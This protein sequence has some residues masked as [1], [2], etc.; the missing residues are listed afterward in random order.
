MALRRVAARCFYHQRDTPII[1]QMPVEPLTDFKARVGY[2]L[3]RN[4][5]VKHDPHPLETELAN[6]VERDHQRYARIDDESASHYF[7]RN[8][9]S[10]DALNRADVKQIQQDL[11]GVEAYGD[12]LATTIARYAPTKRL[13]DADFVDPCDL[14]NELQPPVRHT[15]NRRLSDFMVLIVKESATNKWNVPAVERRPAETLRMTVDRAFATHHPTMMSYT[16]S[17]CPQALVPS[18]EAPPL[19]V[20]ATTY[21]GGKPSFTELQI[22]DHAWVTR[23]ELSEYEFVDDATFRALRDIVVSNYFDGRGLH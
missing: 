16:F 15:L 13:M 11:F 12:A 21:L 5:V 19:Y 4:A 9:I 2:L 8:G 23:S 10:I 22:D 14:K 1:P 3:T 17:N 7:A 6:V 20:F 18:N